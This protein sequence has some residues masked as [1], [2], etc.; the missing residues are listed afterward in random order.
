MPNYY[1]QVVGNTKRFGN[2]IYIYSEILWNSRWVAYDT[3]LL[4]GILDKNNNSFVI[5]PN[6]IENFVHEVNLNF[7]YKK[8]Q[9]GLKQT[10]LSP[11]FNGGLSHKYGGANLIIEF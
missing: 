8:F 2:G 5:L 10:F 3:T 11:E 7:R 4:G 9:L 1:T 6:D